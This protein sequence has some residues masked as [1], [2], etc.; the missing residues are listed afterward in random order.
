MTRLF[1]LPPGLRVHYLQRLPALT[2]AEVALYADAHNV[3]S[4]VTPNA[5]HWRAADDGALDELTRCASTGKRR[6]TRSTAFSH[7]RGN[8]A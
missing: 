2:P 3:L 5:L 4:N 6:G 7:R 8:W 1:P